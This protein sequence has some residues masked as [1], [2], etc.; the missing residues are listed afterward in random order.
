M[1]TII[2]KLQSSCILACVQC[3]CMR[4]WLRHGSTRS[5]LG[6]LPARF[7]SGS[8]GS[9][10]GRGQ[11]RKHGI[12]MRAQEEDPAEEPRS[13]LCDYLLTE[14]A[15]GACSP[16]QAQHIAALALHDMSRDSPNSL[17]D[18]KALAKAGSF[19]KQQ[20]NV[21]REVQKLLEAC[22]TLPAPLI[23][24]LPYKEPWGEAETGMLLPH[25]M[26]AHV[27]KHYK[28][29]WSSMM[30]GGREE[31]CSTFWTQVEHHPQMSGHS[32]K[33]RRDYKNKCVPLGIHGDEVPVTG[34]GKVWSKLLLTFSWFSLLSGH[35]SAMSS[36][37]WISGIWC[38]MAVPG[39]NGTLHEFFK[40]LRW[41][42]YWLWL[43][44]WP[45]HDW[46]NKKNF[47]LH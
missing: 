16:Q 13:L 28:D 22:T 31:A 41:S 8:L 33:S 47:G 14:V 17:I 42:L 24:K 21:N 23:L 29:A 3:I 38:S 43:G 20:Q 18:L 26:F 35:C 36:C 39:D 4:F 37:I 45:T 40:V 25:E 34:V 11:K 46:N 19:G 15:W 30:M 5:S 27:Y 32:V 10:D 7:M 6:C 44:K 12:R 9:H 2:W 1:C